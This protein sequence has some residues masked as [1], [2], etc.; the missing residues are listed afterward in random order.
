VEL[1]TRAGGA[2]LDAL[3]SRWL[4]DPALPPLPAGPANVEAA[5]LTG[6]I[7]GLGGSAGL[8]RSR[9]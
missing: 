8:D 7:L 3:L 1:A 2:E 4:D 6:P 9:R 5:P